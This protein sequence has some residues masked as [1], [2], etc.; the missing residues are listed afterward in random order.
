MAYILMV[1]IVTV[2]TVM[3]CIV[4][5][6]IVMAYIVM[7]LVAEAVVREDEHPVPALTRALVHCEGGMRPVVVYPLD[8]PRLPQGLG[9]ISASPTACPLR[10]YGRAGTQNDRLGEAVMARPYQAVILRTGTAIP[11]QRTCRRRPYCTYIVRVACAQRRSTHS[12]S[13][14]CG[15]ACE[16]GRALSAG[17][18]ALRDSIIGMHATRTR[19]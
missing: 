5:A 10:G 16:W 17:V 13:R 3:A 18:A 6:Y 4:T 1:Y 15:R 11:A 12:T 14:A 9:S 19:A 8:A 2:Y 7:A